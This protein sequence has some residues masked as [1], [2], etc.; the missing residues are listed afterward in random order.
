MKQRPTV[1]IKRGRRK[2][3]K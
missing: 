1:M 2:V 3:P